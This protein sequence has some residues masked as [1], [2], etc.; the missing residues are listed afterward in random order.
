MRDGGG[1]V[2]DVIFDPAQRGLVPLVYAR[3]DLGG[4]CRMNH[5]AS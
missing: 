5:N 2:S 4:A 1:L 3:T